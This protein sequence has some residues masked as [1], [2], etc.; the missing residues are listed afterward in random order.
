MSRIGKKKLEI[1]SGV[2]I[3]I[4]ASDVV[5]KGPKGELTQPYLPAINFAVE[6][7][8]KTFLVTQKEG[9]AK[10]SAF[11]GL[12][13]ALVKNMIEGVTKGFVKQL[14]INGV[15]Y[16]V[17]ASTGGKIT[18][19]IGFSKPVEIVAPKGIKIEAPTPLEIVVSGIDKQLVGQVAAEIRA[20]R[21]PE[22][23]KGKGIRYKNEVIRRKA[24]KAVGGK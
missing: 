22:P 17:V 13:R 6:D 11:Q 14:E 10:S 23:Y 21:K 7:G 18:L 12:Y 2:T 16:K 8:G 24:G 4:K 15:G 20:I 9:T 3:D 5:V 1:P 19:N